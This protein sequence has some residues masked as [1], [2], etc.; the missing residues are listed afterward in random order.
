MLHLK[1]LLSVATA[2]TIALSTA[3]TSYYAENSTSTAEVKSESPVYITNGDFENGSENWGE[4][5]Y[6]LGDMRAERLET[7]NVYSGNYSAA[8]EKGYNNYIYTEFE[9]EE[10][11]DYILTFAS[12]NAYGTACTVLPPFQFQTTLHGEGGYAE[13]NGI[14]NKALTGDD[15]WR[16]NKITFNSG[17]NKKLRIAFYNRW[18]NQRNSRFDEVCVVEKDKGILTNGDFE[19]GTSGWASRYYSTL[20]EEKISSDSHTGNNSVTV[21]TWHND[22]IYNEFNCEKNADYI[23]SF[24]HKNTGG[25]MKYCITRSFT[26]QPDIRDGSVEKVVA[27]S[28]INNSE[29]WE[30]V[31][32]AFNSGDNTVLRFVFANSY[33]NVN[34]ENRFDDIEIIK[35]PDSGKSIKNGGFENNFLHWYGVGDGSQ[36]S[37]DKSR[38]DNCSLKL[39]GGNHSKVY[40]IFECKPD[41]EYTLTFNY[42]AVKT[43]WA[44]KVAVVNTTANTYD[45]AIA[46]YNFEVNDKW[47]SKSIDFYSGDAAQ[48]K[49]GIQSLADCEVYI[50]DFSIAEKPYV[51]PSFVS[52]LR[53]ARYICD[54]NDNLITGWDFENSGNWNTESFMGNGTISVKNSSLAVSGNNV[55]AFSSHGTSQV[56]NIFYIT[57]K[58]NTEYIFSAWVKGSFRSE[59]NKTDMTFG[60]VDPKSNTFLPKN[61]DAERIFDGSISMIPPSWDEN[62]HIVSMEFN[63]ESAHKIGIAIRGTCSE[64]EFDDLYLMEKSNAKK[65][66][67]AELSRTPIEITNSSPQKIYCNNEDNIIENFDFANENNDFWQ[68]GSIFGNTVTIKSTGGTKG[69][70]LYYTSKTKIPSRVY[71]IKWVNVEK[72][73]EY[74]F[75]CNY[76]ILS[77][78]ANGFFGLINGSKYLPSPIHKWYLNDETAEEDGV[79]KKAAISFNTGGYDRI[80]IVVFDGGGSTFLDDIRLFETSS[81]LNGAETPAVKNYNKSSAT[82]EPF[83]GYEYSIDGINFSKSNRFENLVS[84]KE[85]RFYQR[86]SS[87]KISEPL[88]FTIEIIGDV[89]G[90]GT[91]DTNDL[92]VL[93]KILLEITGLNNLKATD[94]NGDGKIDIRDM[95]KL[96]KSLCE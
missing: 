57:V 58:P 53:G 61:D 55:L 18:N 52:D 51:K 89:N 15:G 84:G 44:T 65:F 20:Q 34:S 47:E 2:L 8:I 24:Y 68:T 63:S 54:A 93:R 1:K 35:D 4:L 41:T 7:E 48:L 37:D 29:N 66:V 82:L 64:A 91:V 69:N 33:V 56:N 5:Y 38:N 11:K 88:L 30:K 78:A 77:A 80:G 12:E 36:I 16:T 79:W 17:N 73:T 67:S 28:G 96:K 25:S 31:E 23:L 94:L 72:Y 83:D 74:T 14:I 92:V 22:Y 49:L 10:N 42:Y 81:A 39:A 60:I 21:G 46:E 32:V 59:T 3:F 85:Y 26:G 87:G 71:Y 45:N 19:S 86:D 70:A 95:V 50:D 75:S 6:S 9:C 27:L 43:N 76:K 13:K 90:D 40:Q 62:W